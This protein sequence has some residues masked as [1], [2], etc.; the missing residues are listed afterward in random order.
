VKLT[1][2]IHVVS[3]EVR[4]KWKIFYSSCMPSWST[5]GQHNVFTCRRITTNSTVQNLLGTCVPFVQYK[6]DFEKFC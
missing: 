5:D 4:N 3:A 2:H 1:N 6:G